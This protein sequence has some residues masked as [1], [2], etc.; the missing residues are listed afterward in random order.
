MSS[1]RR[2]SV[3]GSAVNTRVVFAA[4][5]ASCCW[6][7]STTPPTTAADDPVPADDG[8]RLFPVRVQYEYEFLSTVLADGS[9]SRRVDGSAGRSPVGHR[10][11]GRLSVVNLWPAARDDKLLLLHVSTAIVIIVHYYARR[12]RGHY[13]MTVPDVTWLGTGTGDL[14]VILWVAGHVEAPFSVRRSY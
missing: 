8:N 1:H 10:V 7:L 13:D 14:S 2:A 5:F 9:P 3:A 4:V 6:C 11:A 12:R